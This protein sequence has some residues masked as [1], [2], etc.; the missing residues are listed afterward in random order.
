MNTVIQLQV[1][2]V[3]GTR[4]FSYDL[5]LDPPEVSSGAYWTTDSGGTVWIEVGED[6]RSGYITVLDTDRGFSRSREPIAI[7]AFGEFSTS[8]ELEQVISGQIDGEIVGNISGIDIQFAGEPKQ[9]PASVLEVEGFFEGGLIGK[10]G[11]SIELRIHPDGS[12]F[13]WLNGNE[14]DLARGIIDQA[15]LFFRIGVWSFDSG[16][17]C[18]W[19]SIGRGNATRSLETVSDIFEK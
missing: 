15:G 10:A 2:G 1:N 18:W 9:E 4:Y 12:V 11:E 13:V 6:E 19:I 5:L 8:N 7:N 17:S 14:L 3:M 16:S